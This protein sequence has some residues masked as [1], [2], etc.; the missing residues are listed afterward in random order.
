MFTSWYTISY[1]VLS[2]PKE[3]NLSYN[4]RLEKEKTSEL[5]LYNI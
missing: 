1:N 2:Y 3:S 4:I 5:I